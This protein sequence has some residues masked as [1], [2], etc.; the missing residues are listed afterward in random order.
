MIEEFW[1]L[2]TSAFDG[3]FKSIYCSILNAKLAYLEFQIK[4]MKD[5]IESAK[6][7]KPEGIGLVSYFES[8]LP[9]VTAEREALE[10]QMELEGCTKE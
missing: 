6:V 4:F 1:R 3:L 8:R 10:A 2:I 5:Y 7:K 9:Q